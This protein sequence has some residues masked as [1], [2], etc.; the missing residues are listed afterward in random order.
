MKFIRMEEL[1]FL[2]SNV[3]TKNEQMFISCLTQNLAVKVTK[4][5]WL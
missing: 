1:A 5:G 2:W 4:D 3:L